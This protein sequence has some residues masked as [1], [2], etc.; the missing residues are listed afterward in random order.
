MKQEQSLGATSLGDG[1]CSF[2]LWAP[3]AER[4]EVE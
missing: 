1:R 3:K 2:L 4:V